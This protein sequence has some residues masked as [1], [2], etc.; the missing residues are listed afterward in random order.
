MRCIRCNKE[1][2]QERLEF[3]QENKKPLT[4]IE[5]SQEEKVFAVQVY[6]SKH[7]TSVIVVPND[8]TGQRNKGRVK[9]MRSAYFHNSHFLGKK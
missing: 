6:T 1:I 5:H 9:A 8:T 4:C 2:L 7:T 3:L